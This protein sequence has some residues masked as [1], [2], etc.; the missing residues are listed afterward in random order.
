MSENIIKIFTDG[1]CKGNPGIG[2]WGALI[3]ENSLE[4]EIFGGSLNTTNNQMEL[5]ATIKALEFFSEP[6]E[7]ELY[8][9]SK[10]VKD[11]I[12]DWINKWKI[13]GWVNA[14][15]KPV[16]NA[17]L[18]KELDKLVSVHKVEWF[19]VKGHSNHRENDIADELANRGIRDL[20]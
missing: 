14:S 8:T 10:Y 17:S 11:G 6:K 20:L 15:K 1:A 4:T 18:W 3:I 9:D 16:K 7:I 2:G 5:K 13:N 12:T 19:W